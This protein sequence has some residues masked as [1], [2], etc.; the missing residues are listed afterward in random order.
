VS[1]S[2]SS[3]LKRLAIALISFSSDIILKMLILLSIIAADVKKSVSSQSKT[4]MVY[5]DTFY[6]DELRM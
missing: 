4:T 3:F 1:S 2:A 5:F 6:G